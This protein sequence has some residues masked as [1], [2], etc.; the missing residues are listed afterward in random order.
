MSEDLLELAFAARG[1]RKLWNR[2]NTLTAT[3]HVY[4]EFWKF[5]GHGNLLGLER[6]TAD[7]NNQRISMTPFG[8]GN[9]L[10]FDADLDLVTITDASRGELDR[11]EHPR[12]SMAGFGMETPWTSTQ[13]GY[14]ISYA[15][16]TYLLVPHLFTLPGVEMREIEPWSEDG[17]TW[18]RLELTFPE[19]LATHSRKMIYYIDAETGLERRM[20]YD[21]EVNGGSKVAH[22]TSEYADF[23]GLVVPR[24]RRVLHRDN[25]NFGIHASSDILL[26]VSDVILS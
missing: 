12:A 10:H 6:V 16:W 9:T 20:D 19:S 15:M 22:Y 4:G 13:M 3:V 5:K 2:A 8:E 18:R 24:R 25:E 1:G 26:D 11:L 21:A 23:N 7:I 14:F 17:E